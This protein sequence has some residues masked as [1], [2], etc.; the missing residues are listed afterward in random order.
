M[1]REASPLSFEYVLLGLLARK[2]MHGWDLHAAAAALDGFELFWTIKRS[3]LYALLD[4]LE[5]L[6]LVAGQAMAGENRPSR[7]VFQVTAEG[8]R[9]LDAWIHQPVDSIR[10]MRQEFFAR[11]YF[12]REEGRDSALRLVR[13]QRE[14]CL[15]WKASIEAKRN[16]SRGPGPYAGLVLTHRLAMVEATLAWLDGLA[17]DGA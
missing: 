16:P 14:A 9:R 5:S 6:G 4:K 17:R 15:A 8:R 10:A 11:L 13:Q 1:V 7:R 2:P 12:A 3:N